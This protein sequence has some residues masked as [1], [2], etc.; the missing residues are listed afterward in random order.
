MP[1]RPNIYQCDQVSYRRSVKRRNGSAGFAQSEWPLETSSGTQRRGYVARNLSV[2]KLAR[3]SWSCNLQKC[4]R[5][6]PY[7]LYRRRGMW[8]RVEWAVAICS[9]RM[10][11][12]KMF[13]CLELRRPTN[14]TSANL[15]HRTFLTREY[16]RVLQLDAIVLV[17]SVFEASCSDKSKL[18]NI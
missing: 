18:H 1:H 7:L 3:T 10:E 5:P 6:F 11:P 13:G 16:K 12:R 8:G 17:I 9:C 2:V 14:F 15:S 4:C